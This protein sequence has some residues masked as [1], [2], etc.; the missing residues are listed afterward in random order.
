MTRQ[1]HDTSIE[2]KIS[3]DGTWMSRTTNFMMLSFA[4]LQ[5]K[6]S[7]MSS[8]SNRTV[9]IVN[10]PEKYDKMKTSLTLFFQKVNELIDKQSITIDRKEIKLKFLL[11]VNSAT[12]D[13][14]WLWCK[15]FKEDRWDTSKPPDYYNK[16]PFKRDL[17]EIK[18]L[19]T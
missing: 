8:K 9:A 5:A 7:A 12:T 4:L 13:H 2:V 1:L 17:Q 15:N 14:A 6:E 19:S 3:G 18:T 16:A 10:G 11:G